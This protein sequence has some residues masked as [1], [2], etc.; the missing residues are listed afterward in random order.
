MYKPIE[1]A[2]RKIIT[3]QYIN[4]IMSFIEKKSIQNP[5]FANLSNFYELHF[6]NNNLLTYLPVYDLVM[7]VEKNNDKSAPDA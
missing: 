3:K 5:L 4:M 1:F 7:M 6:R 2:R